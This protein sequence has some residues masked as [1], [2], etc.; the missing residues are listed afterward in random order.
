MQRGQGFQEMWLSEKIFTE[1]NNVVKT[2]AGCG[3]QQFVHKN[4]STKNFAGI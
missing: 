1:I 4:I 3:L 2:L